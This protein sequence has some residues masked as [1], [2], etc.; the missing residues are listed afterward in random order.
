MELGKNVS[1]SIHTIAPA[2][3]IVQ[4]DGRPEPETGVVTGVGV[5][6]VAVREVMT[7]TTDETSLIELVGAA[8]PVA[9]PRPGSE[10]PAVT[11]VDTGSTVTATQTV[12]PE[13][14]TVQDVEVTTEEPEVAEAGVAEVV[15]DEEAVA[16]DAT[17]EVS[18]TETPSEAPPDI[19][20]AVTSTQTCIP[21]ELS[22]Q[23]CEVAA[24]DPELA[25]LDPVK[26]APA[27]EAGEV[28]A[29]AE[30]SGTETPSEAPPDI[31]PTVTSTQT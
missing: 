6:S 20:P 4:L 15:P 9:P 17:A 16:V 31:G 28:D 21:D 22:V 11:P 1:T 5:A 29:T 23:D 8:V 10:T 2:A 19:G 3:S 24:R 13:G 14:L 25:E 26:V 7:P 18:G 12:T 30:V 27:E